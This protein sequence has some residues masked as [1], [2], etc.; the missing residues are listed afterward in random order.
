ML[1]NAVLPTASCLARQKI[2]RATRERLLHPVE[3]AVAAAA[4]KGEHRFASQRDA[5]HFIELRSI[6]V[7]SNAG[8]RIVTDHQRLHES[9]GIA[10]KGASGLTSRKE[11]PFGNRL[12][13][14]DAPT[15][16]IV[17]PAETLGQPFSLP[18]LEAER[19]QIESFAL[20]DQPALLSRRNDVLTKNKAINGRGI[21]Q[22][23]HEMEMVSDRQKK[24][25]RRA[26]PAFPFGTL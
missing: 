25:R 20:P 23:A 26:P 1:G 11:Q 4:A 5:D 12:R 19:R 18:S 3:F 10:P 6:A 24:S 15:V 21:E 16:K 9:A 13:F 22:I 14:R 2:G 7:P 17:V 8:A